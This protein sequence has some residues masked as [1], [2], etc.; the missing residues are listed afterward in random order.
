MPM[1]MAQCCF[2]IKILCTHL[3]MEGEDQLPA[4]SSKR[5]GIPPAT[6]H[7]QTSWSPHNAWLISEHTESV[8]FP[9]THKMADMSLVLSNQYKMF[10]IKT[11]HMVPTGGTTSWQWAPRPICLCKAFTYVRQ[12]SQSHK[13]GTFL[14]PFDESLGQSFLTPNPELSTCPEIPGGKS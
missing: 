9:Y 13:V 8:S 5:G 6:C 12:S 14:F 3:C 11:T 2:C 4:P 7:H 1:A 10:E